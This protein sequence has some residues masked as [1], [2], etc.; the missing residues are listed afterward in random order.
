MQPAGR[1]RESSVMESNIR[2][3]LRRILYSLLRSVCVLI[4]EALL[5]TC[6]FD[7]HKHSFEMEIDHCDDAMHLLTVAP[8]RRMHSRLAFGDETKPV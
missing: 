5:G 3:I 8:E 2:L 7:E 1:Q 4:S 6:A